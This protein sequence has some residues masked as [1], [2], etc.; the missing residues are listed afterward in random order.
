MEIDLFRVWLY[1]LSA[2]LFSYFTDILNKEKPINEYNI[3]SGAKILFLFDP[4]IITNKVSIRVRVDNV[5]DTTLV[6]K[7]LKETCPGSFLVGGKCINGVVR[8]FDIHNVIWEYEDVDV[9]TLK[10]IS[11]YLRITNPCSFKDSIRVL[12]CLTRTG[13][14]VRTEIRNE[15]VKSNATPRTFSFDY[16]DFGFKRLGYRTKEEAERAKKV[17]DNYATYTEIET[18]TEIY[19]YATVFK[20]SRNVLLSLFFEKYSDKLN[21]CLYKEM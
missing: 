15:L 4:D 17:L 11:S 16:E 10:A 7:F 5:L 18:G 8:E 20:L 3:T 14:K 6:N 19:K 2:A 12:Y 9:D 21:G 13:E 1:E